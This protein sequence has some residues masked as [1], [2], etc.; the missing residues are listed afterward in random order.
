MANPKV[1]IFAGVFAR[2]AVFVDDDNWRTLPIRMESAATVNEL[3]QMSISIPGYLQ[4]LDALK[5]HLS[6][7]QCDPHIQDTII[8][9]KEMLFL[10][11]RLQ[12]W[13]QNSFSNM[14][15]F[16][17]WAQAPSGDLAFTSQELFGESI[18]FST[19]QV[20]DQVLSYW[21]SQLH[22]L[23]ALL[24]LRRIIIA[25]SLSDP[26]SMPDLRA[27][28]ALSLARDICRS[29]ECAVGWGYLRVLQCAVHPQ[30][31]AVQYFAT[32]PEFYARELKWCATVAQLAAGQGLRRTRCFEVF[33]KEGRY[34]PDHIARETWQQRLGSAIRKI[35][36]QE[37]MDQ[38]AMGTTAAALLD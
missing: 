31:A 16:P 9:W 29:M 38:G 13:W 32:N 26:E 4:Q 25:H 17:F 36:E 5:L 37:E 12:T 22:L 21:G 20:C 18:Y 14:E 10:R 1:K 35:G 30:L 34:A 28:E 2:R 6:Y 15:R 33:F 8:L 23:I 27:E 11:Q 3:F 24:E 19:V 7:T